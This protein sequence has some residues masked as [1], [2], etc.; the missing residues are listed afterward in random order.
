MVL[1]E[2]T[3]LKKKRE[4]ERKE[5]KMI[6]EMTGFQE[7][8]TDATST[9]QAEQR[10]SVPQVTQLLR[11]WWTSQVLQ[12]KQRGFTGTLLPDVANTDFRCEF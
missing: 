9:T 11:A 6:I 4:R 3:N 10:G 1:S 5:S 8:R 7:S 12:L 2:V